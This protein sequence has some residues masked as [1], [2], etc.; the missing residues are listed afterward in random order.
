MHLR[1]SLSRDREGA[2]VSVAK[3]VRD[4]MYGDRAR[5][6]VEAAAL[7]ADLRLS[8]A[9]LAAMDVSAASYPLAVESSI[10]A[11]GYPRTTA[12][13]VAAIASGQTA[14]FDTLD[15]LVTRYVLRCEICGRSR[16]AKPPADSPSY[17]ATGWPRC[18]GATMLLERFARDVAQPEAAVELEDVPS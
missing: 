3:D 16:P 13:E 18:C 14:L 5:E 8:V 2:L 11:A 10:V 15:E 7:P 6:L 1:R 9:G 12:R 4:G 17:F